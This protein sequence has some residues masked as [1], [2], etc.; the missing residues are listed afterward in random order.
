M[1]D[2]KKMQGY[3]EKAL[4]DYYKKLNETQIEKINK[5]YDCLIEGNSRMNLTRILDEEGVAVNHFADSIFADKI[6][7]IKAEDKIIDV[8][9]GAGFPG[10]PI[11]IVRKDV[12]VTC[13]EVTKKKAD[14]IEQSCEKCEIDIYVVAERAEEAARDFEHEYAY[15]VCL[16]RAVGKLNIL[17]E[18]CSG[19]VKIGGHLLAYKGA[20]SDIERKEAERACSLLGFEYVGEEKF[21][22]DSHHTILIYKRVERMNACYPRLFGH[23][24][25]RPL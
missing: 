18:L 22:N 11:A 24:K 13:L 10:V 19:F 5:Y 12:E 9:S 16:C 8:G 6:G 21:E 14:F 15:D 2:Y 1:V 4:G 3:L 7:I 17:M 25:K 23:I 20:N